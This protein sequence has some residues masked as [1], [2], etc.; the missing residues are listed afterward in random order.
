M[1]ILEPKT[2]DT[3]KPKRFRMCAYEKF[4][5]SDSH[6]FNPLP[7]DQCIDQKIKQSQKDKVRKLKIKV[8]AVM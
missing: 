8:L 1:G 7:A 3:F 6:L 2:F 5:K 4:I